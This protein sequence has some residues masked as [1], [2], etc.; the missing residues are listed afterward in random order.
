MTVG[1]RVY[2]ISRRIPLLPGNSQRR[3]PGHPS[4]QLVPQELQQSLACLLC[5]CALHFSSY[6]A[7][8]VC[9]QVTNSET[10]LKYHSDSADRLLQQK[11]KAEDHHS[12]LLLAC[13][14]HK[15]YD[16]IIVDQVSIVIPVLQ[17]LTRSEVRIYSM[18]SA[19][20]C[21]HV[22]NIEGTMQPASHTVAAECRYCF[23]VT[24]LI[25]C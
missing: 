17:L 13:R 8:L 14:Q 1:S 19:C 12:R 21:V 22:A 15:Q 4:W 24:S 7:C 18:L 3:L 16:V 5:I 20:H 9:L 6:L 23:T 11:L 10:W 25:F 2:S